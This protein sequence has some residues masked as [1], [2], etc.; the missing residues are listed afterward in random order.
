MPDYLQVGHKNQVVWRHASISFPVSSVYMRIFPCVSF[1]FPPSILSTDHLVA[2]RISFANVA[3]PIRRRVIV[4][5][6]G[7]ASVSFCNSSS[8]PSAL[9]LSAQLEQ[10]NAVQLRFRPTALSRRPQWHG[11][12]RSG[13]LYRPFTHPH[14]NASSSRR[15]RPSDAS[16]AAESN[17]SRL[18]S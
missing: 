1:V 16:P 18:R 6:S 17:A 2:A 3:C 15:L 13:I 10:L 5:T 9:V 7:I 8:T 12:D 11:Y 4:S 14:R